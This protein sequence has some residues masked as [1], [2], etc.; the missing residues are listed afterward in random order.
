MSPCR[1]SRREAVAYSVSLLAGVTAGRA[2]QATVAAR[3][4]GKRG[5]VMVTRPDELLR[6][7][8]AAP[9]RVEDS[10]H[11]VVDD[12]RVQLKRS[13]N[14]RTCT[15]SLRNVSHSPVQ[16]GNIILFDLTPHD[17][18]M[19]TPVYAEAFQMLS[20]TTGT[21]GEPRDFVY[22]DRIHYKIS[23]PDN[24]RTG[25][26]LF[27]LDFGKH[28]WALLGFASCHR[29]IG[30]I[31]WGPDSLRISLDPEGLEL[32]PGE[33]WHLEEF[34]MLAGDHRSRLFEQLSGA[35]AVNHPRMRLDKIPTGWCSWY[36]YGPTVTRADIH[37]NMVEFSRKMPGLEYIQIDQGYEPFAGDWLDPNPAFGDIVSLCADIHEAG[38]SPAMWVAPFIAER[39][40]R[41]LREHPDWFVKN[42]HGLPLDS[43]TVGFGGWYHGPWYVLDG[44]HPGAQEYI[45]TVFTT[46]R[47][48]WGVH[49]FKLDANYWG[50]IHGGQFHDPG[51]T[52]IEAYRRGMSA[53]VRGAGPGAVILGCNAPMWPSLGLV[54]AMRTSNDI[55]RSW[56]SVSETAH[57]NLLR[58]WQNGGL[59]ASDPDVIC[60]TQNGA[61]MADNLRSFHATAIHAVG[62]LMLGSDK[63]YDMNAVSL[64]YLGKLVM[65]TGR[66]AT[67]ED[68]RFHV[69]VTLIAGRTFYHCFNW[70][71]T[72]VDRMLHLPHRCR[73]TNYWTNDDLG[74]HEGD[75]LVKGLPARSACLLV[76]TSP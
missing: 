47:E 23:E 36:C 8:M 5:G 75:Y 65:S 64:D 17:L 11:S 32:K 48:K 12:S 10:N 34:I 27:N 14:G 69:G 35:L 56:N 73:L 2:A 42:A 49:Y 24:L 41:V 19:Q 63:A 21:L 20:Q 39:G 43:S 74:V 28:G 18:D 52:R 29:F 22:P 67:F 4:M 50:A 54:N 9:C 66:S 58:S 15:S 72:P 26:G 60:L 59:W 45:E 25:Y 30:R 31:S 68:M 53:V 1:P 76:S 62:G 46:M 71:D 38:Y 3:S 40:S 33:T 61:E 57:E 6:R 55:D 7:I 16:V 37:E 44:T 13:W 51:A 70:D